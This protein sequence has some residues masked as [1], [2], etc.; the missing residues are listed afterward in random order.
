MEMT[1]A[2]QLILT[3]GALMLAAGFTLPYLVGGAISPTGYNILQIG[4]IVLALLGLVVRARGKR[5]AA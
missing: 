5:A 3:I 4:G 1:K 2:G